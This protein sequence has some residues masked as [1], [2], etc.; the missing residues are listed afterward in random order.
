MASEDNKEVSGEQAN[1]NT[2]G[3]PAIIGGGYIFAHRLLMEY[4]ASL[5]DKPADE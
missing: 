4:F 5:H 1:I 3:G 2:E